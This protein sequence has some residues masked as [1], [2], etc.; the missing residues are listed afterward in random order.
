VVAG[1]NDGQASGLLVV[2]TLT[3]LNILTTLT[4]ITTVK[5]W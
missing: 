2:P 1:F 4:T 3:T 5:E